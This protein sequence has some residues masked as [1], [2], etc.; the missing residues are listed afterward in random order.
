MVQANAIS[1]DRMVLAV[2]KVR[3]RL[4]KVCNVLDEAEILYALAGDDA[5]AAWVSTVDEAAVRNTRDV[6]VMINRPDLNAVRSVLEKSG[7]VYRHVAGLDVF[8]ESEQGSV[9]D[10]VHLLF[11]NEYVREGEPSPNPSLM[12]TATMGEFKVLDLMALVQIKLTAF[13]DKDRT[14]IRDMIEVGLI[15]KSWVARLSETLG[16]RLQAI[17]NDPN[18]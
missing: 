14:H 5:V 7:F 17:L 15:D 10:A 9:R 3:Q 1:L 8:L 11:A 4:L 6:D 12:V 2:A 13:R 16:S 18:G